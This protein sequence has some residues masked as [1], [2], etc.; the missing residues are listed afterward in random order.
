MAL[1][2]EMTQKEAQGLADTISNINWAN[3]I[4][5]TKQINQ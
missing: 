2:L 4:E 1:S 3:P 5:A